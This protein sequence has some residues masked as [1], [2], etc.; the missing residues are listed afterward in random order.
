MSGSRQ[1][2]W[3]LLRRM[4][5]TEEASDRLPGQL[6]GCNVGGAA[7]DKL[8][9]SGNAPWST[10]LGKVGEAVG[11]RDNSLVNRDCDR[12]VVGLDVREDTIAIRKREDRPDEP[13]DWSLALRRAALR[14]CAKCASA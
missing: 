3:P 13:H 14:L 12:G 4:Q 11:R 6:I 10:A 2:V 8:T 7:Y 1:V 5:H 9:G